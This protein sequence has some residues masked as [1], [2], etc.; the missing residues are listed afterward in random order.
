MNL[1]PAI[2]AYAA[3]MRELGR[4]LAFPGGAPRVSEAVDA[5][6]LARALEWAATSDAAR[7]EI[8]NVT[9][10]DVFVWRAVWPAIA[11]ALGMDVGPDEPMSLAT[12]MPRHD[13]VWARI[14][15]RHQLL[16]PRTLSDFVG[17]SFVY[18]DLLFGHGTTATTLPV[19]ASTIKIRRA[20][21]SD[22]IDTEDMFR[23]W[24]GRLQ[25]DRL[26]PPRLR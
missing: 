9:N 10:G 23:S 22:C 21:F 3:I 20:G 6:L 17:Q 12:T 26:L 4:P 16:A 14:V 15:D 2:G 24:F 25:D 11:D 13:D 18:A 5:D 19:L 1:I 8:F 7:D